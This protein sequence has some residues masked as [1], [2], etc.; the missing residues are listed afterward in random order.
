MVFKR[1]YLFVFRHKKPFVLS[2]S[3][4]ALYSIVTNIAPILLRDIVNAIQENNYQAATHAFLIFI[5]LKIFE[6]FVQG[7]S[8]FIADLVAIKSA[9]DVRIAVFKHLHNLDFHYHTNKA[10]GKLISVF[11]RGEGAFFGYYEEMNVWGLKNVL[12]FVFLL[13]LLTQVYQSLV[14]YFLGIFVL[15]AIIMYFTVRHNIRERVKFNA[16][17]DTA[18]ML[19]VDNM[20]AFD[21][22]KYFSNEKYEQNRLSK[23][24]KIWV[25]GFIK[26]VLTFRHIDIF[27]GG[28]LTI[29]FIGML[30]IVMLDLMNGRISVGDFVLVLAVGTNF[31][32]GMRV[33][34]FRLR[35][36]AKNQADLNDYLSILDED[37]AVKDTIDSEQL[38][39]WNKLLGKSADGLDIE[40]KNV[41]FGYSNRRETLSNINISIKRN[42]S[43]A[44]VG[45]SGVGKTTMT[46]LLMRFY[47]VNE[48]EIRIGG[49]PIHTISKEDLRNSMGLVPQETVLFNE[50]IGYNIAYGD[51]DKTEKELWEAIRMAN[52]EDFIKS[53]PNGL[54][55]M[56]G[57]RGIKLSGGQKQR[58]A[59]ARAF[60]KDAPI[61]IFD[62]ATSSLDSESERL[63]Q[64]SLWKL[65]KNRTTIIIAHRLSTVKKVDRIIVFDKGGIV[66]EGTHDELQKK[67]SGIYKYLWELQSKGDIA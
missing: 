11:K 28:T 49:V 31:F 2:V 22:V 37:I 65:A 45:T 66:E 32:E 26:Y 48:G 38:S 10:S 23:M 47:D 15:N 52:L 18:T 50:S 21:T 35:N 46:K 64:K 4:V 42:Q 58:L 29:G 25:E 61:I 16:I 56:V 1:F 19:T 33:L 3:L 34:V 63:I 54:D 7:L 24:M 12:D 57:E 9:A 60:M 8:Q 43:V 36:L 53:L 55:T 27:N 40:F 6:L 67:E 44:F 13:I 59:I 30:G 62:E 17:E 39:K 14:Y 5:A 41:S 20:V 51:H